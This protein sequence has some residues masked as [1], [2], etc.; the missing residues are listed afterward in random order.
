MIVQYFLTPWTWLN[1][2]ARTC[3]LHVGIN[4]L[5]ICGQITECALLLL[6]ASILTADHILQGVYVLQDNT[7]KPISRV[8]SWESRAD[9]TK[10]AKLVSL[11]PHFRAMLLGV[12]RVYL[13]IVCRCLSWYSAWGTFTTGHTSRCGSWT[14]PPTVCV[15]LCRQIQPHPSV[16]YEHMTTR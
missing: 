14:E 15:L 11:F 12:W 4:K 16:S 7:F 6:S 9:A 5:T 2:S 13:R 3:G 8:S 10:R 1:L